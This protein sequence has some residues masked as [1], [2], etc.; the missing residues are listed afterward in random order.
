MGTTTIFS[1]KYQSC[2]WPRSGPFCWKN[3]YSGCSNGIDLVVALDILYF[4]FA[5]R[6]NKSFRFTTFKRSYVNHPTLVLT[7]YC[8]I[9]AAFLLHVRC[10]KWPR[11]F[12]CS[13][14]APM[15]ANLCNLWFLSAPVA[16][17]LFTQRRVSR[18]KDVK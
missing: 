14:L 16:R 4:T 5:P 13:C 1:F 7:N 8:Q 15:I 2:I 6:V 10:S 17:V 11:S 9:C 12:F 18:Q 3:L